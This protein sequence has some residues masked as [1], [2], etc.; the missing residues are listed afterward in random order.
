[1][2]RRTLLNEPVVLYRAEDGRPVASRIAAAIVTRRCRAAASSAMR[3]SARITAL[4]YEPSGACILI[5]GQSKIP[6]TARVKSYPVVERYRWIWI[7]MGDPALADP[8]KI[9][10][11]SLDGRPEWRAAGETARAQGQLRPADREPARPVASVLYPPHDA[12]HPR[13]WRRRR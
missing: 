4:T 3:S 7:W 11:F 8:D 13:R 6:P 2:M 10:D 12:R 5:P 9:E 1:M